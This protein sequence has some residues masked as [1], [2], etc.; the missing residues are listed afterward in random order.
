MFKTLLIRY[1]T[2][3]I[4]ISPLHDSIVQRTSWIINTHVTNRLNGL[5]RAFRNTNFKLDHPINTNHTHPVA[6]SE[7]T[8]VSNTIDKL[9]GIHGYQPYSVSMSN[10]DLK[11]IAGDRMFYHTKDLTIKYRND[12]LLKSNAIKLIDVDYY[13]DMQ[14]LLRLGQPIYLYTFCPT[15]PCGY[16]QSYSWTTTADD[17]IVMKVIGGST[18][19]HELWNYDV[20]VLTSTQLRSDDSVFVYDVER[21]ALGSNHMIIAILPVSIVTPFGSIFVEHHPLERRKLSYTNGK[22]TTTLVSVHDPQL[23]ML[24]YASKPNSFNCVCISPL[25]LE[26]ISIRMRMSSH[27]NISDVERMLPL[28]NPD[29]SERDRAVEAALLFDIYDCLPTKYDV[30]S[31][32][33]AYEPTGTSNITYHAVGPLLTEDSKPSV[34][35]IGNPII[36]NGTFAP[37]RSYNND[38]ASIEGRCKVVAP[39]NCTP[40]RFLKELRQEFLNLLIP[41]PHLC[42]PFTT[43]QVLALQN[44]PTQMASFRQQETTMGY[45]G[46]NPQQF[47]KAEPMPK[48]S[49]P[50]SITTTSADFRVSYSKYLYP[51]AEILKAEPWYAFGKTPD[52]L[53]ERMRNICHGATLITP[54][55]FSRFDGTHGL[56]FTELEN[57]FINRAYPPHDA[58]IASNLLLSQHNVKAR[59]KFGYSYNTEDVRL[60]GS[61][62]TS[63][64]NTLDSAFVAYCCYRTQ[65]NSHDNPQ[66]A[67]N[68]LGLYGGDDGFNIDLP[69]KLFND[70]SRQLGLIA[71][72]TENRAGP[73]T[74]LGRIYVDPR[75]EAT[76]IT[77]IDRCLSKFHVTASPADVPTDLVMRRKAQSLVFTDPSTP[78]LGVLARKIMELTENCDETKFSVYA[79]KDISWTYLQYAEAGLLPNMEA[80][81]NTD[82]Y[83][84][85]AKELNITVDMVVQYERHI[86]LAQSLDDIWP[87]YPLYIKDVKVELTSVLDGQIHEK[88]SPTPVGVDHEGTMVDGILIQKKPTTRQ[89]NVGM[90][91]SAKIP[92]LPDPPARPMSP[93]R[94]TAKNRRP[95][96]SRN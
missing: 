45:H 17:K 16:N 89:P 56:F 4:P 55:D 43:D 6:A 95:G 48:I 86:A 79:E 32:P 10:R 68:R 18:Y 36:G 9:I 96:V 64:F 37:G 35:V 63:S 94:M 46:V 22:N 1:L 58:E 20:D 19:T 28:K 67:Y 13:Q 60:S 88:N 12:Q 93:P 50:R 39:K 62:E 85:V 53:V 34:R 11:H 31:M 92:L 66:D 47:Q 7:R 65:H 80:M 84:L 87:E 51:L 42:V 82:L 24:L 41:T 14:A 27:K 73:V 90:P 59:T 40:S 75:H 44:R 3:G 33:P 70:I 29:G 5:R 54:T 76:N 8:H 15:A 30:T 72:A 71:K 49:D 61:P 52:K 23:G 38:V 78:I 74:F 77:D 91:P 2:L 83:A 69:A 26:G 57:M 81:S 21:R 25:I